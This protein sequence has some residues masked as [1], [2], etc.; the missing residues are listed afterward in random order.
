MRDEKDP[1][2]LEMQ[3][4]RKQGRPPKF[5][6]GAMSAAER[7]KRYRQGLRNEARQVVPTI[8]LDAEGDPLRDT[9]ILEALRRAMLKGDGPAVHAITDEL[10]MR[11]C[12]KS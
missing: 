3:L 1:G 10:R 8:V 4:P 7:A 11:Y 12:R 9:A 5:S 2:T 6:S